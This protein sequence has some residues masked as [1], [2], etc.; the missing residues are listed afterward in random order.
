MNLYVKIPKSK[1]VLFPKSCACCGDTK[2]DGYFRETSPEIGL[3]SLLRFSKSDYTF[4][5]PSCKNC[6]WNLKKRKW[7]EI[8]FSGIFYI[9]G[10]IAASYFFNYF[11]FAPSRLIQVFAGIL[12]LTPLIIMVSLRTQPFEV[13]V[14]KEYFLF[15]FANNNYTNEFA[16]INE[17][18]AEEDF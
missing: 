2:L 5:I 16:R 10:Y 11:G 18:T 7:I 15:E 1:E 14:A 13:V 9:L 12:F 6:K 4:N 17:S 3:K 8:L